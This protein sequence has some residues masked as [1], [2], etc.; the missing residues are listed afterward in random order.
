[1]C[2]IQIDRIIVYSVL[3]ESSFEYL[4]YISSKGYVITEKIESDQKNPLFVSSKNTQFPPL[5]FSV[6]SLEMK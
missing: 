1:M 5:N 4:L 6:Y 2:M 3:K